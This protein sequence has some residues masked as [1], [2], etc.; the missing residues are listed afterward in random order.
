MGVEMLFDQCFSEL[1]RTTAKTVDGLRRQLGHGCDPAFDYEEEARQKREA[2]KLKERQKQGAKADD[3]AGAG[4]A[5]G[6]E[7]LRRAL[8]DCGPDGAVPADEAQGEEAAIA[9]MS[10]YDQRKH[11]EATRNTAA[12]KAPNRND[13]QKLD[14]VNRFR[15]P[16]PGVYRPKDDLLSSRPK[17]LGM[18]FGEREKSQSRKVKE[19]MAEVERLKAEGKPYDHLTKSGTSTQLME[20]IPDSSLLQ[21]KQIDIDIGKQL[22]RPDLVK[23]A[24]I[25]YNTNS[26]TAGVLDGDKIRLARE[27]EWDFAKTSTASPKPR[28][29][30]FQPG[31]YKP[32]LNAVRQKLDVKNMPFKNQRARK[33]LKETIG[34]IEIDGRAG[35]HLPDRSLSRSCPSLSSWPR[36]KVP[37]IE[38]Y[39][40]RP[41]IIN[42]NKTEWHNVKDPVV[43]QQVMQHRLTY[44][45]FDAQRPLWQKQK[46]IK[47]DGALQRQQE[48]K[49]MRSYG[50]DLCI[51][52]AKENVTR[53][54]VS[55]ELLDNWEVGNKDVFTAIPRVTIKNFGRMA[56]REKE[57]KYNIP[58][59]RER[60]NSHRA[61]FERSVRDGDSRCNTS[62]YSDT[63]AGINTLRAS[64]SFD[65]GN[66]AAAA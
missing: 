35:D 6:M 9:Q 45:A 37:D 57:K 13:L 27:P 15:A 20:G 23:Q 53:G 62:F 51:A 8:R 28:E 30:Y 39:S 12:F 18:D 33:P 56:G 65:E 26:F 50:Q 29:Y 43:D 49:K 38:K 54:P 44:D 47:F 61:Q 60:D 52:M 7:Q 55:V 10:P 14:I 36:M 19:V 34:R 58:P 42:V 64:R 1:G 63:A 48:L 22:P 11:R 25:V 4:S 32:N 21:R 3:H 66:M 24:G 2:E 41:P 31:Q 59:A 40:D 5:S 17:V 16:P 46:D